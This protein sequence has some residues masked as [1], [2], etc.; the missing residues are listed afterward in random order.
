MPIKPTQALSVPAAR[1][2]A[3]CECRS[4]DEIYKLLKSA[5][6][7]GSATDS[8]ECPVC[9]FL[10]GATVTYAWVKLPDEDG[11]RAT[12]IHLE[13]FL[14]AMDSRFDPTYDDLLISKP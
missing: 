14:R 12:S 2:K 8:H 11:R 5:N 4:T 13:E 6:V 7:K 10:C 1:Y 9:K 3:L